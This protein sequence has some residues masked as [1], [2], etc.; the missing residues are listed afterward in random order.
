MA[1]NQ[2]SCDVDKGLLRPQANGKI[3]N[4]DIQ[5]CTASHLFLLRWRAITRFLFAINRVARQ[6]NF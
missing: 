5:Y 1:N 3:N 2:G 6:K 4:F